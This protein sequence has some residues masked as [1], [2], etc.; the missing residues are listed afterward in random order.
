M[1]TRLTETLVKN[2]P[3]PSHGNRITY[4]PDL[5]GFG[6]RVTAKGA[7]AFI[8]NYRSGGRERRLTIGSYPEWSAAAARKEAEGLKRRIDLGADP[9]AERHD[10]RA[11]A[12]MADLC[13][14]YI[15]RHLPKKRQSS[16]RDDRSIIVRTILPRFGKAKAAAIRYADVELLH[17]DL[18]ATAPYAANRTVA[19]L[20]KMFSLAI[21]WGLVLENP[22]KGIERNPEQPR[23]RFLNLTELDRLLDAL[24]SYSNQIVANA[25]RLMLLTGA[26]KSEV[27][28]ATW[29][30]FDLGAGYW[31]K[32][33][34][35][36]KQKRLHRVPLSRPTVELLRGIRGT[37]TS[38]VFLFPAR[39]PSRSIADVK[40]AW[41]NICARA[42]LDGVRL[43]DLRHTYA[44]HLA[45]AGNSLPVI[46]A[47][48]G[49]TQAQTTH[50]YAHLL[51]D[52]LRA[53]TEQFGAAVSR[54]NSDDDPNEEICIATSSSSES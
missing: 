7:K 54:T 23:A 8:L 39:D 34:A 50:R 17:R 45:S 53:A 24:G 28:S 43:H 38:E 51:D 44:S 49:H 46:G 42:G 25:I 4:D 35:T 26:R 31:V 47:L 30:Q 13:Q 29:H 6:V 11:A 5:K 36:V 40:K 18:S 14:L 21:K 20:S 12:T 3:A 41:A 9:M 1:A 22:T 32:P 15:E 16:Q 33:A 48:L 19:L 2:L 52:P 27:L 10:E 37:A